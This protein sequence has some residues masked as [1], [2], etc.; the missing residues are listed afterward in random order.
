MYFPFASL[1]QHTMAPSLPNCTGHPTTLT[2]I[3]VVTSL[4]YQQW[5]FSLGNYLGKQEMLYIVG[6]ACCAS[7]SGTH[8]FE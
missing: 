4:Q 5:Y 8:F 6:Y 1:S 7:C 2:T 3:V